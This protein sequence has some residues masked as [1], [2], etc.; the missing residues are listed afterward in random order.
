MS[1]GIEFD[2]HLTGGP[3]NLADAPGIDVVFAQ[4][5]QRTASQVVVSNAAGHAD[6]GPAAGKLSRGA[7]EIHRHRRRSHHRERR[8]TG[9]RPAQQWWTHRHRT[10]LVESPGEQ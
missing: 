8:P 1:G 6:G 4:Y 7:S 10:N 9:L 3:L 2:E 5:G